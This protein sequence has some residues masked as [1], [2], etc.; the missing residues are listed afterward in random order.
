MSRFRY[1]LAF[2]ALLAALGLGAAG[3][4]AQRSAML[5]TGNDRGVWLVRRTGRG[6]DVLIR[7]IGKKW[8]WVSQDVSG[9]PSTIAATGPQLH[10]LLREPGHRVFSMGQGD[11]TIGLDP[12]PTDHRW[13][14]GAMPLAVCAAPGGFGKAQAPPLVGV[15]AYKARRHS[16]RTA[17]AT[18]QAATRP[19]TGPVRP[20][21]TARPDATR[22][23][24]A[25]FYTAKLKEDWLNPRWVFLTER[26]DVPFPAETRVFLA[27]L[28]DTLY[29]LVC[30]PQDPNHLAY[31][32]ASPKAKGKW[33]PIA[34]Q[35]PPA[36]G[37]VLGML[38]L[39]DRLTILAAMP[40]PAGPGA[41]EPERAVH[42][43]TYE[44][45]EK[46]FGSQ[47][48][49]RQDKPMTWHLARPPL[50][51]A[52]GE[53]YAL[54]WP[55]DSKWRFATCG[56][57]GKV[58]AV[59]DV[60]IFEE[61]PLDNDGP[62]I[63]EKL[64][65][66]LVG[67]MLCCMF[68]LRPRTATRS[69]ASAPHLVPAPL[70]RR[71][72]AFVV[73]LVLV[74]IL[75]TLVFTVTSGRM[76]PEEFKRIMDAVT[77]G[78]AFPARAAYA[79]VVSAVTLAGYGFFLERRFGGTAGKLLF[80]LRTVTLDGLPLGLR[81]AALRNLVKLFEL[82]PLLWPMLLIPLFNRSRMRLGDILARTIVVESGSVQAPPA[83]PSEPGADQPPSG[84]QEDD[85]TGPQDR[86]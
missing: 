83:P 2:A 35:G 76:T 55:E 56:L 49:T 59:S 17:P 8:Q 34:L 53:Q 61:P 84:R 64:L 81:E 32:K 31:W 18:S 72:L 46:G 86:P 62:A 36:E 15:V 69:L 40:T 52:M 74:N 11:S 13:P 12:Q 10:V 20:A 1:G 42:V 68:L 7:P 9:R 44:G 50:V 41:D 80:R 21:R 54:V 51:A 85:R 16:P 25:V 22:I 82:I 57:N 39:G 27:V 23:N 48:I 75:A 24:L 26:E 14:R 5:V 70:G 58:V 78:L 28:T 29:L 38:G 30:P 63:L 47:V 43:A 4:V 60:D 66:G 3:A 79:V 6:F 65:W 19:T 67:G 71:G 77:E 45:P 33:Q 73:D 37:S